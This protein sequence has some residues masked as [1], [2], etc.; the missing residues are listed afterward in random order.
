MSASAT[1]PV[2]VG[3]PSYQNTVC[4]VETIRHIR[5][6]NPAPEEIL[7]YIDNGDEETRQVL[8]RD[9]QD[10]QIL[11]CREHLGPGGGRNRLVDV[12]ACEFL[13]TFD[14]DSYP[15]DDDFFQ[16]IHSLFTDNPK[17]A[18]IAARIFHPEDPQ[19]EA[20]DTLSQTADFV[21]CGAAYRRDAFLR[22]TGF[23]ELPIAYGMEEVDLALRLIDLNWT[24]LRSG[25][26]RVYHNTD[27]SHQKSPAIVAGSLAN[28]A[29]LAWLRYPASYGWLGIAQVCHRVLW[30][31]SHGGW[32]GLIQGLI[33]IPMLIWK[34][35]RER[36]P[37][38]T[39]TI[40]EYRRLRRETAS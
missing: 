28:V 9:H 15:L 31:L 3:I 33:Q 6:C 4:L 10:V 20:S 35:R 2:S 24:I 13:V 5:S 16:H 8:K 7:V 22:T 19:Q 32:N 17:S 14:D 12:A 26:L 36:A 34:Y 37:V 27:R 29:L 38:S 21:N 30:Q 40:R 25:R 23:L 39:A 1:V 11:F 18:V